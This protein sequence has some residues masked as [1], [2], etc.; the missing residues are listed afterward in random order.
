MIDKDHVIALD[1]FGN[2]FASHIKI[3][4]LF[5]NV[6]NYANTNLSSTS[7]KIL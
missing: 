6:K 1:N 5:K 4:D 2:L 3:T 7:R